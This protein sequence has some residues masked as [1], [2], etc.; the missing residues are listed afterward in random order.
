[1]D[2]S[3]IIKKQTLYNRAGQIWLIYM[4]DVCLI[5]DTHIT[6]EFLAANHTVV[7][8]NKE[9]KQIVMY[10]Y[11]DAMWENQIHLPEIILRI[12]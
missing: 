2:M 12:V 5:V 7:L 10:E 11:C 3:I 8:L 4:E 1:M 6:K 9:N